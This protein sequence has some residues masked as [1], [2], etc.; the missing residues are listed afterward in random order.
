[1]RRSAGRGVGRED[2]YTLTEILVVMAIIGLI[3]AVLTPNL[4]GQLGRSRAKT[5][6]VQVETVAAAVEMFR[7][8]VGRY[9]A[10]SEGLQ[11]LIAQPADGDGWTGP[12]VRNDRTLRDP[13]GAALDYRRSEDGRTFVV[14]SLGADGQVGGDGLNRD[15]GAPAAR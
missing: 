6:Q 11:A 7:A 1:M 15:L 8:D 4:I 9:P 5:A 10:Q 14:T 2:G 13:W 3:A 12:Y